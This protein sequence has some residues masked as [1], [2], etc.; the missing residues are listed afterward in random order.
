MT[1]AK[2]A[3]TKSAPTSNQSIK[4]PVLIETVFTLSKLTVVLVGI[5]VMVATFAHGNPYWVAMLRGGIT[6][7]SLG[8]LVWFISWKTSK[9]VIESARS[10]LKD[11][12]E[13]ENGVNDSSMDTLA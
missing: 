11:A 3:A 6:V 2:T 4:L 13:F 10:M 7:L 12:N 5:I 9:G 8:L 1:M